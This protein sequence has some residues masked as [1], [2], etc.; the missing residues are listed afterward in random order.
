MG[1]WAPPW[2]YGHP[3]GIDALTMNML[4]LYIELIYIVN[5]LYLQASCREELANYLL[6][7]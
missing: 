6:I 5:M 3:H 4:R 2:E 7:I 1:K